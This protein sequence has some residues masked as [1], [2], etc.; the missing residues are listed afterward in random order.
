M[1]AAELL[2][3]LNARGVVLTPTGHGTIVYAGLL[4]GVDLRLLRQHKPELLD[5]LAANDGEPV[6]DRWRCRLHNSQLSEVVHLAGP[7]TYQQFAELADQRPGLFVNHGVR[8]FGAA[9]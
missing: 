4:S 2:T 8:Y 3:D 1:T 5:L 9:L 6:Y 7:V